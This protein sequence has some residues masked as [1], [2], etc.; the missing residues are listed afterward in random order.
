MKDLFE[1]IGYEARLDVAPLAVR[2]RPE[3]LDELVGQS[4]VI[5]EG[6]WLRNAIETDSLFSIILYGPAGTGKTTLA[7][8]IAE[9]TKAHFTE[10]S[11]ISG[12]VSDLRRVIDEATKRLTLQ[13]MRT[14]LFIDEIHR[15]SR[16]QQDA[17]LHAVED[18]VVILIGATT[19]NPYFEVNSALNSRSRIIEFKAL[20][21]KDIQTVL[22][23]ALFH[24]RGLAGA[25]QLS[26]AALNAI[27]VMAAG[28]ARMA[29]TTL[30]LAAQIA[31]G[32]DELTDSDRTELESPVRGDQP[33]VSGAS[34]GSDPLN[35]TL[36]TTPMEY[37]AQQA[38]LRSVQIAQCMSSAS[39]DSQSVG[40]SSRSQARCSFDSPLDCRMHPND[41]E[42]RSAPRNRSFLYPTGA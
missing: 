9:V 1:Q 25:Y 28:D 4:E 7:R 36:P 6:T 42:E 5:G 11:A 2:M 8:I 41:P 40:E 17:L 22:R 20:T 3:S 37:S 27:T 12:G 24:E 30:E 33:F 19:E 34:G 15:F 10:V 13:N 23:R 29:L 32:V 21:E 18:R 26:L 35:A 39:F 16:S 38:S 14:I 31:R